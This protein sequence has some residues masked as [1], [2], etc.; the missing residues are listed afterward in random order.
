MFKNRKIFKRPDIVAAFIFGLLIVLS[1]VLIHPGQ[2]DDAWF[3]EVLNDKTLPEYL[4]YRYEVWTARLLIEVTLAVFTRNLY[5]WRIVNVFAILLLSYSISKINDFKHTEFV[6]V[7]LCFFPWTFMRE[8]GWATTFICY[9]WPFACGVWSLSVLKELYEQKKV[10]G[11]RMI[12]AFLAFIYAVNFEQVLV[13]FFCI[14]V[15]VLIRC[16]YEKATHAIV[17]VVI[18]LAVE[19]GMLCFSLTCPGNASRTMLESAAHMPEFTGFNLINKAVLGLNSTFIS[20]SHKDPVPFL[21]FAVVF[22]YALKRK[23]KL[24]F[25]LNLAAAAYYTAIYALTAMH[26]FKYSGDDLR[27]TGAYLFFIANLCYVVIVLL[28]LMFLT[29]RVEENLLLCTVFGAGM[30]TRVMMGFSPTCFMSGQRTYT[31]V[32]FVMLFVTVRLILNLCEKN[33]E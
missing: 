4:A 5:V 12:L 1:H 15:Y 31:Y 29:D 25:I 9:I 8:T 19:M 3:A 28:T 7:A 26:L 32:D 20:F 11:F 13:L 23:R 30:L 16:I 22:V 10:S 6:F 21:F 27:L 18:L 2:R 33:H 17:P 24:S 14:L